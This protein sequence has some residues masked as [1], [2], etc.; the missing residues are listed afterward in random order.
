M[1]TPDDYFKWFV[2]DEKLSKM[3]YQRSLY[4][5]QKKV[6]S[7]NTEA[8]ELDQLIGVYLRIRMGLVKMPNQSSCSETFYDCTGVSSIFSRKVFGTIMTSVH[9]M[10]NSGLTEEIR[11]IDRLWKLRPRGNFEEISLKFLQND[12]M[13]LMG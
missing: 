1:W 5:T 3:A 11:E 4:T 13:M 2:N 9:F 12:P 6:K 8:N 7:I 10:D